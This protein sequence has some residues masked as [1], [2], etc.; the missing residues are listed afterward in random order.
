MEAMVKSNDQ[1]NTQFI[2]CYWNFN[3]FLRVRL[4]EID[5]LK[6]EKF[7]SF[8]FSHVADNVVKM[9]LV[10]TD[11]QKRL[12]MLHYAARPVVMWDFFSIF[13]YV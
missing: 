10:H 12:Q 11:L 8:V 7:F 6:M 1:L 4:H 13:R 2:S 9:I 5:V 3:T